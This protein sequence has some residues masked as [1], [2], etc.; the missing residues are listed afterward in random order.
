MNDEDD[1]MATWKI[2][3]EKLQEGR[4]EQEKKVD[5]GSLMRLNEVQVGPPPY[6]TLAIPA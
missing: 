4:K 5:F 6:E 1:P 3:L 2:L